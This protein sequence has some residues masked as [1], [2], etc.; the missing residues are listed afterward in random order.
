[1]QSKNRTAQIEDINSKL[2]GGKNNGSPGLLPL[3]QTTR[4]L[5]AK[6]TTQIQAI[7]EDQKKVALQRQSLVERAQQRT[8]GLTKDCFTAQAKAEF[9]CYLPGTKDNPPMS[10]K[11]YLLCRY[12]QNQSQVGAGGVV[13][14]NATQAAIGNKKADELASLLDEIFA[15]SP[16]SNQ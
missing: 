6:M 9:R 4:Q 1:S 12:R 2:Q 16:D 8:M 14:Q 7:K 3:Q 10:A 5:V 15:E 13:I 11:D